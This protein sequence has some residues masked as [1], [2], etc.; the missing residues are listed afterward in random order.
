MSTAEPDRVIAEI[1]AER[2]RLVDVLSCLGPE[3]WASPSL[4]EGWRVREVVAHLTMPF[5]TPAIRLL[6]GMLRARFSFD[7]FADRDARAHAV[8]TPDAELLAEPRRTIRHSWKPPGGGT[9]GALS[10]ALVHGLDITEPLGLPAPS[11]D[12]IALALESATPRT[13]K[14]FGADLDGIRLVATDADASMGEGTVHRL[15]VK[16]MLLVVTGRRP[17]TDVPGRAE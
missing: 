7:R 16:Q 5:R 10:H 15:P 12:R 1:H 4:C 13:L 9:A 11:A 3:Q 6:G 14:Y 8:A 2:E 17:L